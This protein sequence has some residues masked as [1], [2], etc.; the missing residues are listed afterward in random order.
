MRKHLPR[1]TALALVA[2][3]SG[4]LS[5]SLVQQEFTRTPRPAQDGE[6]E[7]G[8]LSTV[9]GVRVLMLWGEPYQR[10][11]AHGKLLAPA[12]SGHVEAS[13][14]RDPIAFASSESERV[15]A[16]SIAVRRR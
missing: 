4:L 15:G 7:F 13:G 2:G 6:G 8:T 1:F 5:C 9:D 14:F 10:G 11:Y 12:I 3:L 16:R